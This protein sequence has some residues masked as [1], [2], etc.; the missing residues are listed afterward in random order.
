MLERLFEKKDHEKNRPLPFF[1]PYNRSDLD[2]IY[3]LL[4]CDN[5]E[6]F[7]KPG[8]DDSEPWKS[9]FASPANPEALERIAHDASN[10]GRIR[11]LAFNRLRKLGRQ[12]PM[13]IVLGVMLEV[14]LQ[15][16][17]DVLAAFSDGGV[18]HINHTGKVL[19]FDSP[20]V[21]VGHLAKELLQVS[22]P[23]V[24]QIGPWDKARFA[25]P[26]GDLVRT[27]IL[28]SDG[29]YFGQGPYG[30]LRND[31]LGEAV[32]AAG[33]KLL[34]VVIKTALELEKKKPTA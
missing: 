15:Q 18:R 9:L 31:P 10:E 22:Q 6:L 3:N 17:L 33:E 4:F 2:F 19:L 25:P 7:R 1:T 20:L 27:T 26:T 29:L 11:A 23:L 21:E 5:L 28:V 14:P 13:K 12:V 16:G 8:I 32:L 34:Q 24:N 30:A